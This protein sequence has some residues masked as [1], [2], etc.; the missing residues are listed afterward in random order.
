MIDHGPISDS[1]LQRL[2][3]RRQSLR[4]LFQFP[5]NGLIF[6][7]STFDARECV[8]VCQLVLNTDIGRG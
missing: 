3:H 2:I 7:E 5:G 6:I 8:A 1:D 4:R